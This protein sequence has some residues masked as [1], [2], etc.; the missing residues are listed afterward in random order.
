MKKTNK[1]QLNPWICQLLLLKGRTWPLPVSAQVAVPAAAAEVDLPHPSG[2][3]N[4]T[5]KHVLGVF[6]I[7]SGSVSMYK[8]THMHL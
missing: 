5:T 4:E 2:Q 7:F 6:V 3:K 1:V 8:Y